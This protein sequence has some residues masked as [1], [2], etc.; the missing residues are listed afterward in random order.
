MNDFA[1]VPCYS[2]SP[3]ALTLFDRPADGGVKG[4]SALGFNNILDNENYTGE[5][6][7]HAQHRLKRAVSY[8]LY[9]AKPK[10]VKGFRTTAKSQGFTTEYE[11][12]QQHRK[13]VA[14]RL[15]FITL[16]LPAPQQHPDQQV[17]GLALHQ[18]L[19]EVLQKWK[20]DLYLWKAEKQGNGNIHFH[21]LT[22]RYIPHA[23]LRAAW[24]RIINKHP[25]R[26]VDRYSAKMKE[27]FKDGFRMLP[28]D[29][30]TEATQRKAYEK[31]KA[32]GWT[33]PNS[34]DI[35]ALYR[36]RNVAAYISKY[37]SKDVSNHA[38][39]QQCN[40]LMAALRAAQES[41]ANV[42]KS[43]MAYG[44]FDGSDPAVAPLLAPFNQQ[45]ESVQKQLQ[46]LKKS[47][48]A[49]YIWG[50]SSALSRCKNLVGEENWSDIPDADTIRR[51]ATFYKKVEIGKSALH[52][53]AFDLSKTP[54]LKSMLDTHISQV[55]QRNLI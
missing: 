36:V 29:R 55:V 16:T 33:E 24:N 9:I 46:E 51:E 3:S 22:T 45:I 44:I 13:A 2:L 32:N 53:Y 18:F 35:H 54:T 41:K 21:I 23:Q 28:N 4:H 47:G 52:T 5:L 50:C 39:S 25:L 15:T 30:R 20:A 49:G 34:T 10:R 40:Q 48:V 43:L 14:Y 11:K 42:L 8:M 31:N 6:S 17:K 27:F 7:P 26:Y 37:L 38:R 19:I 1:N 12:G